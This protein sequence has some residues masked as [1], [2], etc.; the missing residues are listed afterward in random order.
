M[1]EILCLCSFARSFLGA[2]RSPR[3][4][5]VHWSTRSSPREER[6]AVGYRRQRLTWLCLTFSSRTSGVSSSLSD[7]FAP[8]PS[9]GSSFP[10]FLPFSHSTRAAA[11]QATLQLTVTAVCLQTWAFV[12]A[13]ALPRADSLS[14]FLGLIQPGVF[15]RGQAL[16]RTFS[17]YLVFTAGLR[18][19][20]TGKML[21]YREP[22]HRCSPFQNISSRRDCV[23]IFAPGSTGLWYYGNELLPS[24]I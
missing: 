14:L 2:P 5:R 16:R 20:C 19:L 6:S 12:F 3:R 17:I 4:Y 13:Q 18:S 15:R 7:V 9:H 22:A 21:N 11:P 23:R 24:W 1:F 10:S 8:L